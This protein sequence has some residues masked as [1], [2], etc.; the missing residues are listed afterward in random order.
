MENRIKNIEFLRIIACLAIVLLHLCGKDYLFIEGF[1]NVDFYES[2][3]KM[4]RNSQKAVDFFFII[5]GFFFA[6][7]LN[8][9]YS[10]FEFVRHKVLR[11]LPVMLFTSAIGLI[12]SL[13]GYLKWD[14]Y[15]NLYCLLF[16]NGT[17][18]SYEIHD[19][20]IGVSWYCSS[21]L[22]V[23][24]FILSLRK[25]FDK[26]AV[27]LFIGVLVFLTYSFLIQAKGGR[28]D[29]G[30]GPF[31]YLFHVGMMRAIGAVGIGYLIGEYY[32]DNIEKIKSA[33]FSKLSVINITLIEF[34]CLF[35]II[36]NLLLHRINCTNKFIFIIVFALT[37]ILFLCNK[38]Y[39][40]RFLNK[41]IFVNFGKYTYSIFMTH[42][43]VLMMFKKYWWGG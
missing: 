16:L 9:K 3:Y 7:K 32:K 17:G 38:G 15:S 21:L 29:A 4:T 33:V 1:R 2:L 40:S 34:I 26:N 10:L 30:G 25:T 28:I 35:F 12:L 6:Y 36:N 23:S 19:T 39:I 41:D 42:M 20:P 8:L 24:I 18:M 13:F 22:W 5:S 31:Y 11:F 27:N 43:I 37:L 14:F